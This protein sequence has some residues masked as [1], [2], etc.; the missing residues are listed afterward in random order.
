MAGLSR[1]FDYRT[2][3]RLLEILQ[4]RQIRKS[5]GLGFSR[6]A[7]RY[8]GNLIRFL[9]LQVLRCFSSLRVAPAGL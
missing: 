6:F 5:A 2:S 8:S 3:D 1:P 4:P 7:R 9:L